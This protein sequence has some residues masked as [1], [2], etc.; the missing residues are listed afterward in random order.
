MKVSEKKFI[1]ADM[2]VLIIISSL[3]LTINHPDGRLEPRSPQITSE[4]LN[5]YIIELIIMED[6]LEAMEGY[7]D[8]CS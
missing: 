3:C 5:H 1:N 2:I 8:G 7:S 4:R 6:F